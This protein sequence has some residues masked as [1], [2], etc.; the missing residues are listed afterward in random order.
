MERVV[1]VW[2]DDVAQI[3][4]G[5]V[6]QPNVVD[7]QGDT[8]TAAEIEQAAHRYLVESRQSDVQHNELQAGVEVVESYV[9]PM[10]MVVGGRKVLKGAWVMAVHITDADL[11]AR[12]VN[13]EITGFSIG[14]TAIREEQAA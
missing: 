8:V 4:Y 2:K 6:L 12:V 5:V 13:D 1:P 10:D 9:A 14:G 7:S 3:V 11:W